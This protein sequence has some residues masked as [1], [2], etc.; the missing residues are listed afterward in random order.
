MNAGLTVTAH[1]PE[2]RKECAWWRKQGLRKV[3]VGQAVALRRHARHSPADAKGNLSNFNGYTNNSPGS[4][5][6]CCYLAL[7]CSNFQPGSCR[8]L[9]A[10]TPPPNNSVLVIAPPCPCRCW[11]VLPSQPIAEAPAMLTRRSESRAVLLP[12]EARRCV[13]IASFALLLALFKGAGG[14]ENEDAIRAGFSSEWSEVVLH[15]AAC[16]HFNHVCH[17]VRVRVCMCLCSRGRLKS[18]CS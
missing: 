5:R 3:P 12:L 8:S 9:A 13:A 7:K 18:C 15:A 17:C 14:V 4:C 10:A 2:S 11:R 6:L 16:P 1:P